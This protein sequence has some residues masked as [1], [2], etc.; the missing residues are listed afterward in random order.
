MLVVKQGHEPPSFTSW[1]PSWSAE[2]AAKGKS[3]EELKQELSGGSGVTTVDEVR[4]IEICAD[5]IKSITVAT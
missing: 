5:V 1:F 3:F 4:K 2:M